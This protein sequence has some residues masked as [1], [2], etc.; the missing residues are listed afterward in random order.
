MQRK[1]ERTDLKMQQQQNHR[2]HFKNYVASFEN[3]E[4]MAARFLSDDDDDD[5]DLN[6]GISPLNRGVS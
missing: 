1:D 5:D 4:D 6:G 2:D 3:T